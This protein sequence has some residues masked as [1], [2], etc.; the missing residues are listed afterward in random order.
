MKHLRRFICIAI[1]FLLVLTG[2]MSSRKDHEKEINAFLE[3]IDAFQQINDKVIDYAMTNDIVVDEKGCYIGIDYDENGTATGL[4]PAPDFD[5]LPLSTDELA[6]VSRI[7]EVL[8][9]DFD[10]I[11]YYGD[12]ISYAGDGGWVYVYMEDDEAPSFFW[13]TDDEIRFQCY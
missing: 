2:C 8:G 6:S 3:N 5:L 10:Y 4:Y 12:R 13:N 7:N 11:D 1:L 9:S